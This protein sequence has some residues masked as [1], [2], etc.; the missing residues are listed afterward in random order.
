VSFWFFAGIPALIF[1]LA[2]TALYLSKVAALG[3][4][5]PA[6]SAPRIARYQPMLRLLGQGD[7]SSVRGHRQLERRLRAQRAV[8]FRGYAHY[9]AIDYARTLAGLRLVAVRSPVDRPDL[10]RLILRHRLAFAAQ[11]CRL[12]LVVMLHSFGMRRVAV[13]DLMGALDSLCAETLAMATV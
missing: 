8:I 5:L 2:F 7:L 12:E 10:A 3:G 1:S 13:P 9:L 11:L 6:P 4:R